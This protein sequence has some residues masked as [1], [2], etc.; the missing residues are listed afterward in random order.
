VLSACGENICWLDAFIKLA[1]GFDRQKPVGQRGPAGW[2][3][4]REV[5]GHL[6]QFIIRPVIPKGYEAILACPKI[7]CQKYLD[8]D[9]SGGYSNASRQWAAKRALAVREIRIFRYQENIENLV[10]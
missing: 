8:A 2:Q 9:M 6:S 5:F 10:F 3:R 4:F 1:S 7:F